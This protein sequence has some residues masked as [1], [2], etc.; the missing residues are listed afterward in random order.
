MLLF[1]ATQS[2]SNGR[3]S[4]YDRII[5]PTNGHKCN[6]F[7][8]VQVDKTITLKQSQIIIISGFI[9]GSNVVETSRPMFNLDRQNI[10]SFNKSSFVGIVATCGKCIMSFLLVN[11]WFTTVPVFTVVKSM[12]FY[13]KFSLR[14]IRHFCRCCQT[15]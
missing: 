15:N 9:I 8:L 1:Q 14:K 6:F 3:T 13:T 11:G 12:P 2:L 7:T 5:M 10:T 4:N